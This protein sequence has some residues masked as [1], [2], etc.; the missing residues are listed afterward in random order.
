MEQ[1]A[2]GVHVLG[3]CLAV[4]LQIYL[5]ARLVGTCLAVHLQIYLITRLVGT[6]RL[7]GKCHKCDNPIT[8]Y[9]EFIT[10]FLFFFN[11]CIDYLL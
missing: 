1:G 7:S 10:L 2:Q 9:F 11:I 8:F 4:H 3:T 5:I 6:D